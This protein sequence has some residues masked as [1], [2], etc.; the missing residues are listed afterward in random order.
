MTRL[1]IWVLPA[2]TWSTATPLQP[3][4][5]QASIGLFLPISTQTYS[6]KSYQGLRSSFPD[7]SNN[8]HQSW[9]NVFIWLQVIANRDQASQ[10]SFI[11]SPWFLDGFEVSGIKWY[12][13]T[14]SHP[15]HKQIS[16][17]LACPSFLTDLKENFLRISP[18]NSSV[19]FC[20]ILASRSEVIF[21]S[22]WTKFHSHLW[23][24]YLPSRY[25]QFVRWKF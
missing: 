15:L 17:L 14:R 25:N 10:I 24:L 18:S 19:M 1:G 11:F 5:R 22:F 7:L 4:P 21:L 3:H 16:L 9:V 6:G 20:H 2:M 12:K 8:L 23:C 13:R